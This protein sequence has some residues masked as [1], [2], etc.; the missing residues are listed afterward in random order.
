MGAQIAAHLANTGLDVVLLDVTRDA[1]TAGIARLKTLKPDPCFVPDVI[2]RITPGGF[3]DDSA[4]LATVDWVIEAVVESLEIKQTLLSK[5]APRIPAGAVVSTNTSGI[6]ISAIATGLPATL[7]SRWLGTHFFNPPRYLRLLEVIPTAETDAATIARVTEFADVRL[8]K[9]VVVAKDTPGFIA[10]RLGMFGALRSI[11]AIASGEFTIEEVDAITGPAIGRPK[12][13]TFRTLDIAGIDV[14]ARVATDLAARLADAGGVSDYALPPLITRMLERGLVGAKAGQG[15]YK[16]VKNDGGSEILVLDPETLEYRAST[17]PKLPPLDATR[18]IADT[19][20]RVRALYNGTDRVGDFLRRTLGATLTYA[21]KVAGEIAESPDDIDR[22]MRLGFGWELG[23][24]ELGSA[25]GQTPGLKARPT[26]ARAHATVARAKSHGVVKSND[27]ASLVDVGDHVLCVEFHSKLNTL[28]GDAMA[29]LQAGVAEASRNFEAVVIANDADTFSAGANLMLVLL[30]AQEGNWDEIDAMVRAFQ[31]ATMALK[32]SPVP[33]VS[34]PAGLTLGGGCEICLHTSHVRAAAE[35]YMGLVEVGVGL[36]P[37]G[38]GTKEMLCRAL[39]RAGAADPFPFIQSAF[40]T[41]G[42]GKVSTSAPDARRLGYLREPDGITMNR[43]RLLEDAKRD[44]LSLARAG[45]QAAAPRARLPVG[46][47]DT[48]ATMALG[49]HLAHRAGRIT[50]HET[51]IGRTIARVLAGGDVPHK[52]M[53]T[54]QALLD[55]E[56][57]G[58]LSLCG[59]R[60]TLERMAYTLRTGKTLRN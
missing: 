53:V 11:D 6:P 43:E 31:A 9:G 42:F 38:G 57:E 49:L 15:F 40:E 2:A 25:I 47:P 58:F 20:A 37:A 17:A 8:G 35:T 41:I 10:N 44:A 30:E 4:R 22:A 54:E 3:D 59:E 48:Y 32:T 27:G 1:A 50:D 29:M 55:L 19:A 28:G 46:G 5:L 36:L 45:Y 51:I 14:F 56:R 23:P 60:K 34:A 7:R 26:T 13:A 21:A 24:F 52:T 12:S 33:V 39:D 16:R 18:G